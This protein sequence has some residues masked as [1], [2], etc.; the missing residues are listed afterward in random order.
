MSST[1]R[2]SAV[3]AL[4]LIGLGVVFLAFNLVPGLQIARTWPVIFFVIALGFYLPA[5]LWPSARQGLAA[6]F[7]PGSVLLVLGL[8]FLYN[9]FTN[10]WGAWAYIWTLIPG[11]VGLGLALAARM[12]GWGSGTL[13][14]GVWMMV[15]SVAAFGFFGT[16]FGTPVLKAIGP[17]A[18]IIAGAAL[19]LR[20]FV[21]PP[22]SA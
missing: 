6:L 4:V 10:D 5:L 18:L 11:G 8:I 19:L 22:Q 1:D 21:R 15:G 12:G 20:T 9:T 14:V 16:L 13:W 2:S 3:V 7:I 17:I